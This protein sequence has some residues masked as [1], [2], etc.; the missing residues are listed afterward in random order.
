[1]LRSLVL[2]A[3]VLPLRDAPPPP[4]Q[5]EPPQIVAPAPNLPAN[6]TYTS[7]AEP[8]KRFRVAPRGFIKMRFGQAEIDDLCGR[9]PCGFVFEGCQRGDEIALPDPFSVPDEQFARIARHELAHH[10]GWPRS[11]GA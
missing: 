11:H 3:M 2:A 9:P 7:D 4:P 1:M 8:P 10:S 5:C 6:S